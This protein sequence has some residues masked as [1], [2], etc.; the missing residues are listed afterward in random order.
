MTLY[1]NSDQESTWESSWG[2]GYYNRYVTISV[3]Q[4]D[5]EDSDDST[6]SDAGAGMGNYN[7]GGKY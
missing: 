6:D 3:K 1:V 4:V 5:S 7:D 2:S